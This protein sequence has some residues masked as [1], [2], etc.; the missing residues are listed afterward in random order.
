MKSPKFF[1]LLILLFLSIS[2]VSAA[3]FIIGR[4]NDSLDT[5]AANNRTVVLYNPSNGKSDNLTDT[6][7]PNGNSG[8]NNLYMIDCEL[9]STSCIIGDNLVIEVID[10]GDNY[11]AENATA[12]VTGAGYDL[13]TTVT[14]NSPPSATNYFPTNYRNVTSPVEFNCSASDLDSNLESI[15]LYTNWTGWHLN[16]TKSVTGSLNST[17][18]TKTLPEGQ[19]FYG[20]QA[21]DNLSISKFS[22]SNTTFTVDN[23]APT[24][25][26]VLLNE[27]YMCGSTN[28]LRVNCTTNDSL[29]GVETVIIQAL[30][31]NATFNFSTSPLATDVYYSDITINET[32]A[33][34]FNCIAT[35]FS[36][37]TENQTS[38]SI[39]SHSTSAELETLNADINFSN[40]DPIENENILIETIVYNNGC[41]DA[42]L[43]WTG[44]YE[45]DP[46]SGGTQIG[47]N[48]T[49]NVSQR[50]NTTVNI[51]WSA[52]I[53][54]TNIFV[55]A[56]LNNS[57]SEDNE[58]NN[59]ANK[60][61]NVDSWQIY[62]GSLNSTK[63]LSNSGISNLTIWLNES[64]ST[65]NIFAVDKESTINWGQ[66]QAF[67]RNTTDAQTSN[68]FADIDA[69]FNMTEYNDSISNFFTTGGNTP[70]QTDSFLVHSNT[71][72]NVPIINSSNS[73]NFTTGILWDT[74]YDSD[75]EYDQTDNEKIVIVTKINKNSF[76]GYG[77]YDYEIN[78]PVRL[79]SQDPTDNSEIYFYYELN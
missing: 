14:L 20:C 18:F 55:F 37:N 73:T 79:R 71:I 30:A 15:T 7:G 72:N 57:F 62:Y 25:Y 47:L 11:V 34:T 65:G 46:E 53:G 68:D 69:L 70:K 5:T 4:V 6:I 39:T 76:G 36:G 42:N 49:I 17:N 8:Q 21:T 59:K 60:T 63:I 40:S 24:I 26:S 56:D 67:A 45:G 43:V 61:I 22:T 35:D 41:Q 54:P 64:A 48:Q 77:Q 31:P 10:S 28:T 75:G 19:Y 16:E 52:K 1:I 2:S 12:T 78:I 9:L 33:W 3:H 23:T 50:S 58:T 44:F 38:T 13:A 51:T 74:S 32:G 29:T 66:L 27:S